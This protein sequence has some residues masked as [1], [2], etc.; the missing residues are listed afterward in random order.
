[1]TEPSRTAPDRTGVTLSSPDAED[2]PFTQTAED[3]AEV[4]DRNSPQRWRSFTI[5]VAATLGSYVAVLA[6]LL[7]LGH[8]ISLPDER[9]QHS[10]SNGGLNSAV[11]ELV[12]RDD[13]TDFLVDYASARAL[14]DGRNPYAVSATLIHGVGPDWPVRTAN[15]HPPTVLSLML[16]TTVLRYDVAMAAWALAMI[17]VFIGTMRLLSIRLGY[18]IP[19]GIAIGLTFPGAYGIDNPVPIIGLGIAVAYRWRNTPMIAA[20]GIA[21]A[22]APKSSGLLLIIPFLL[23]GRLRTVGWTAFWYGL[24]ALIP[25]A[26]DHHVWQAYLKTGTAAIKANAARADNESLLHLGRSSGSSNVVTVGIICTAVCAVAVA[27]RDLFWPVVWASVATL[28]IAWMYS[29]LTFLPLVVRAVVRSPRRSAGL[30]IAAGAV[31]VGSAPLGPWGTIAFPIVTIVV[32][33]LLITAEPEAAGEALWLPLRFDP[34][35][36][37]PFLTLSR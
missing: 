20:L 35:R 3:R 12:G 33:V 2:T 21:L 32:L 17:Y 29:L 6:M 27:R 36:S 5:G 37:W 1:V 18:A 9:Q 16:P 19:F 4:S 14:T 30:A 31:T 22:A 28:P 10:G 8:H 24:S 11:R 26:F 34:F 15:P 7:Y 13:P 23:A 25:L